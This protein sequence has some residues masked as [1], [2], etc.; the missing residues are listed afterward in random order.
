[1][2]HNDYWTPIH[3]CVDVCSTGVGGIVVSQAYHVWLPDNLMSPD[4]PICHLE[5]A[6]VI[7]AVH[8]WWQ[9]FSTSWCI[10]NMTMTLLSTYFRLEKAGTPS[11]KPV[12]TTCGSLVSLIT[13]PSHIPGMLLTS[14]ADALSRSHTGQQFKDR[15]N[16]LI[17]DYVVMI[18][19]VSPQ[20]FVLSPSL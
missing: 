4:H 8:T 2:I 17:R 19:N 18:I 12:L 10:C 1:M 7:V 5:V 6:N 13:S 11:Y 3:L 14:S 20:D 15:V 9:I 16:C